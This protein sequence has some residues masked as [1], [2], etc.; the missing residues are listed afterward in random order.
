[1]GVLP[2]LVEGRKGFVVAQPGLVGLQPG[3]VRVLPGLLREQPGLVW[4]CYLVL[5]RV[6]Q[7]LWWPGLVLWGCDLA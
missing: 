1:V 2:G 4:G 7:A 6:K 3:L 5:L